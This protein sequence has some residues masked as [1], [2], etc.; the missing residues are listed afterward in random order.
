MRGGA[1]DGGQPLSAP[2]PVFFSRPAAAASKPQRRHPW[3]CTDAAWSIQPGADR[4]V[5]EEQAGGAG[6]DA[7][8]DGV[9]MVA[10]GIK[11]GFDFV[12]VVILNAGPAGFG[13]AFVQGVLQGEAV[14]A[15]GFLG[16]SRGRGL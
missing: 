7:G 8:G 15:G 13:L 3:V 6:Q 1:P 5:H 14:G 10:Q 9:R 4:L 11:A 16:W 12:E 2:R